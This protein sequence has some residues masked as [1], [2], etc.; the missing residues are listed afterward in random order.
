MDD[1]QRAQPNAQSMQSE[2]PPP[3][4]PVFVDV[5]ADTAPNGGIEWSHEW[6]FRNHSPKRGSIDIPKKEKGQPGTP[7][8]FKLHD[9]TQPKVGLRFVHCDDAIWVSR[10]TCPQS[11]ASDPEITRIEPSETVLKVLDLNK[12]DCTLHYNLRFEPDPQR[13]CYDPEI[14]NGGSTVA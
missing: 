2:G 14:R 6:R 12:D 11:Q 7:I 4:T 9:R 5:Y 1:T 10:T 13:Y 3:G 8:H